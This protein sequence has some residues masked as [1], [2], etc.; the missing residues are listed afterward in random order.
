[1]KVV[2]R[3]KTVNWSCPGGLGLSVDHDG[4]VKCSWCS[5]HCCPQLHFG[6]VLSIV[7]VNC[8]SGCVLS[9]VKLIV[10][11]AVF[12]SFAFHLDRL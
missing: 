5:T 12:F 8:V 7:V 4:G 2:F 11:K 3:M 9:T 6:C 10:F 1:M